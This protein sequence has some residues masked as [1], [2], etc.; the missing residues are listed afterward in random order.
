MSIT[1][2]GLI[3]IS[4]TLFL[5]CFRDAKSI[6]FFALYSMIFQCNNILS[7]HGTNIGTQIFVVSVAA[8][9]LLVFSLVRNNFFTQKLFKHKTSKY[10]IT[11]KYFWGLLFTILLSN[12]INGIIKQSVINILM[13]FVYILF[14]VLLINFDYGFD[15]KWLEDV[16]KLI[17]FTVI[18]VGFLQYLTKLEVLPLDT[19]LRIFIYNDVNNHDVIFNYKSVKQFYST[20]MEPSYCGALLVGLFVLYI[21]KEKVTIRNIFSLMLISLSILLTESSTAYLGISV[22]L[23]VLF[24]TKGEKKIFNFCLPLGIFFV[25]IF[26]IF[27]M[28]I[29]YKVIFNKS[30]TGSYRVR[31]ALDLRA[32]SN[33]VSSPIYGVGYRN[34]R[35]SSLFTTLLGELGLLGVGLYLCL[36]LYY[37]SFTRNKNTLL[38]RR[39]SLCVAGIMVCQLIACPDLNFSLFWLAV[40][41]QIIAWKVESNNSCS[42][43]I[44]LENKN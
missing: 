28:D 41:L 23:F 3:W 42:N 13:I 10:V 20:L 31:M 26:C 32:L 16:E 12:V 24:F 5:F 30:S 33:F 15:V 29:L 39:H 18:F 38:T 22:M 34:S 27:N 25:L 14:A 7:I 36:F 35:G 11:S 21:L 37:L 1:F 2:F 9:E 40:Y 17:T 43:I 19:M 6:I 8:F 44:S 4:I